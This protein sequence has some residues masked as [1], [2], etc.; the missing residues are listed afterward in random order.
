MSIE[1]TIIIL[2]ACIAFMAIGIF[3]LS[4]RFDKFFTKGGV[5]EYTRTCSANIILP[6][7]LR[8]ELTGQNTVVFFKKALHLPSDGSAEE[9]EVCNF[10]VP[11][12]S[13]GWNPCTCQPVTTTLPI[14]C[15]N[16][17]MFD[18]ITTA[19]LDDYWRIVPDPITGII[20]MDIEDIIDTANLFDNM[21][22]V[23]DITV[24][25]SESDY[26]GELSF[27]V[28]FLNA[29]APS[30]HFSHQDFLET[31][32]NIE[33]DLAASHFSNKESKHKSR[34]SITAAHLSE[35]SKQ[36][37]N[38]CSEIVEMAREFQDGVA[39]IIIDKPNTI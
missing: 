34:V 33:N 26:H 28:S 2:A 8:Q 38:E 11:I 22:D 14:V 20:P 29:K 18:D 39:E 5:R 13:Y 25:D 15:D 10:I 19:I 7:L 32:R 35:L 27:Y 30:M 6:I 17:E 23:L 36:Y 3:S 37:E 4:R 16:I 1:V 31:L 9:I 12:K 21:S 24:A